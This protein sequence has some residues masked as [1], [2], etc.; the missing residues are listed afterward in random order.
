MTERLKLN[1]TSKRAYIRLDGMYLR[2]YTKDD[3]YTKTN[4]RNNATMFS[5][6]TALILK[7]NMQ[8]V[9]LEWLS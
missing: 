4:T 7:H 6:E 5:R 9:E 1:Q 2:L 3:V 8:N